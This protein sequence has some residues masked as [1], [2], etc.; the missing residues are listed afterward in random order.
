MAVIN[1]D[2]LIEL[3]NTLAPKFFKGKEVTIANIVA[4]VMGAIETY[5]SRNQL[6]GDQKLTALLD[7]LPRALDVLNQLRIINA[8]KTV[9]LKKLVTDNEP[10]I[11]EIVEVI[12]IVSK[13][14][15]FIQLKEWVKSKT[16]SCFKC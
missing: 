7:I 16:S 3:L 5:A 1:T 14:P 12:V 6:D 15:N 8:E 4:L 11:R 10:L 2:T 9:E 13:N